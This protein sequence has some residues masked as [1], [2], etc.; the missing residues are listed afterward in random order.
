MTTPLHLEASSS[1]PTD[2]A[3][4]ASDASLA[5]PCTPNREA[6]SIKVDG[7]PRLFSEALPPGPSSLVAFSPESGPPLFHPQHPTPS[8]S[9]YRGAHGSPAQE[10]WPG[11]FGPRGRTA[12]QGQAGG[13]LGGACSGRSRAMVPVNLNWV[14]HWQASA[15]PGR[16]AAVAAES[17]RLPSAACRVVCTERPLIVPPGD[18]FWVEEIVI[19]PLA[20]RLWICDGLCAGPEVRLPT[21]R[22][23]TRRVGTR[24]RIPVHELRRTFCLVRQHGAATGTAWERGRSAGIL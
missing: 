17:R 8:H 22:V 5:A 10:R 14:R 21:D 20:A 24:R 19:A 2:S 1:V 12:R 4:Q 13:A 16:R 9:R 18:L 15:A 3:D 11:R 23:S 7:T 6:R